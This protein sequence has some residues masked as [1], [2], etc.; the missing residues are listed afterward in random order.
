[1][2]RHLMLKLVEQHPEDADIPHW[3]ELIDDRSK[4][5]VTF[6]PDID[7]LFG[8]FRHQL[9]DHQRIRLRGF[10]MGRGRDPIGS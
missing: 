1:M 7:R 2:K 6:L 8:E 4:S 5:R 10:A 9:L 3:L